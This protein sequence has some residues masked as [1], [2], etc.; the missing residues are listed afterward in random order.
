MPAIEEFFVLRIPKPESLGV[1]RDL[2]SCVACGSKFY[3]ILKEL[4]KSS[5]K[6]KT[7]NILICFI[8]NEHICTVNLKKCFTEG[9]QVSY[10]L[11]YN[12]T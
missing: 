5:Y 8:A 2:G 6:W 3:K 7:T 4:N 12:E 9:F 1:L 11:N 10:G